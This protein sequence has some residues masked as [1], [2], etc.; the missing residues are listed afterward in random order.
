[1]TQSSALVEALKR[2][3]K[4]RDITYAQVAKAL[5]L[6]EATIKRM[7]ARREFTLTRIDA[8]CE[9]AGIDL[10][11]LVGNIGR[12]AKT[13][14]QLS[15][16]Q[17]AEIVADPLLML[18]A[19]C[20]MNLWSLEQIVDA[21]DISEAECVKR[22][23][24]LDR[25]G[26]V[27]LQANNRIKLR[28]SRSFTWQPGGPIQGYFKKHVLADFFMSNFDGPGELLQ[29]VTGRVSD[30][31][32]SVFVERLRRL[33]REF[34]QQ[35]VDDAKLPFDERDGVTILVAARPWAFRA[36]EDLRRKRLPARR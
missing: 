34:N 8:I 7:F 29:L 3:L 28:L 27:E 36:L 32:R 4:A 13:L 9:L 22:L 33:A 25:M 6:S 35:H 20:A 16:T 23:L 24:R 18:V 11:D 19:I 12:D 17:E 2:E 14:S 21:Y 5:A 26:I 31:S 10:T 30:A 1:M 15:A